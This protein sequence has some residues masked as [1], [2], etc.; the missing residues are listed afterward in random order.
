MDVKCGHR[1][2]AV[3]TELVLHGTIVYGEF[4]SAAADTAS[5][6]FSIL[7]QPAKLPT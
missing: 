3:V 7:A 6:Y 4:L 1:W 2:T 5:D